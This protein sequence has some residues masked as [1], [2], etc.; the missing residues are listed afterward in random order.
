MATR[1]H[2]DIPNCHA[3]ATATQRH[4]RTDSRFCGAVGAP[5]PSPPE[6]V[7]GR[8][9]DLNSGLSSS[10]EDVLFREDGGQF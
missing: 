4:R 9:A 8:A 6:H 2:F 10:L 5:T 3:A 7:T 1:V